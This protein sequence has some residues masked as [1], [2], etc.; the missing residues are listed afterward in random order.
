[1]INLSIITSAHFIRAAVQTGIAGVFVSLTENIRTVNPD[2]RKLLQMKTICHAACDNLSAASFLLSLR[3]C[4]SG[5]D[6]F[7][8]ID[9]AF[10]G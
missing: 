10:I 5:V 7:F 4:M 3:A 2:F 6:I 8:P 1:M 9:K